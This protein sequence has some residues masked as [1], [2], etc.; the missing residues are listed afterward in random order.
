[1]PKSL[2]S[3]LIETTKQKTRKDKIDFLRKN[4]NG[5]LNKII[6]MTY[7]PEVKFLLPE[8]EPPY[9][10]SKF[11]EPGNLYKEIR[12]LYLFVEG[13]NP[14]LTAVKREDRFIELLE[15]VDAEDAKLLLGMK[16]GKLPYPGLSEKFMQEALPELFN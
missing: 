7:D 5:S 6:Q 4:T 10:P 13:G 9:V 14:N 12:R 2:S 1:M 3:I 15:F 16:D 8:G 11:D